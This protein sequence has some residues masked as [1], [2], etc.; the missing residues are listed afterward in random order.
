MKLVNFFKKLTKKQPLTSRGFILFTLAFVCLFYFGKESSDLVATIIGLT[1]AILCLMTLLPLLLTSRFVF[2]NFKIFKDLSTDSDQTYFALKEFSSPFHLPPLRI[3]PF[4]TISMTR[5]FPNQLSNLVKTKTVKLFGNFNDPQNKFNVHDNLK[6]SRRG[7]FTQSGIAISYGDILGLT[8]FEKFIPAAKNYL[9]YPQEVQIEPIAVMAASAQLGDV[10]HS[11][12]ERTGDLFDIRGYQPGDSLKRVLWKVYA[13]S[14][15]VV[16]RQ[17]EPAIVPEGEVAI[18]VAAHSEDDNVAAAALS[19]LK[20]L[21]EQNII[22][23]L[24]SLGHYKELA[25]TI[26]NAEKVLVGSAN[27]ADADEGK[28]F[29]IFLNNLKEKNFSSKKIIL[30]SADELSSEISKYENKIK[31]L[32]EVE[33]QA[34]QFGVELTIVMVPKK[35]SFVEIQSQYLENER[36]NDTATNNS[37]LDKLNKQLEKIS[38][39]QSL[40]KSKLFRPRNNTANKR[41][42]NIQS[43]FYDKEV[44]RVTY[45]DL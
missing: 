21:E 28:S 23:S 30:F 10:E 35:L 38:L 24:S 4:F 39:N 22:F 34:S 31:L 6:F 32:K 16:V 36:I 3:P 13:R 12:L 14:G 17:P 18:F 1:L 25:K 2:K 11:N 44:I 20:I 9:V 26:E 7:D 43:I 41:P 37:W 15:N 33:T 40:S 27:Q 29:K 5:V 42:E 19:Y 45:N 8:R